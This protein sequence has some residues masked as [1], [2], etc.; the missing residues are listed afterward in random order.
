MYG[1]APTWRDRH[2][3]KGARPLSMRFDNI[4]RQVHE[5]R[6][7]LKSAGLRRACDQIAARLR[8]APAPVLGVDL[9]AEVLAPAPGAYRDHAVE[10]GVAV[11]WLRVWLDCA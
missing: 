5:L 4:A 6:P 9:S 10:V 11:L 1:A 7:E 2:E 3:L 8:E